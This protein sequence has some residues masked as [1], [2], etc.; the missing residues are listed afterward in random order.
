VIQIIGSLSVIGTLIALWNFFLSIAAPG[1]WW[2]ARLHDTLVLFT[3]L[4][5]AWFI[6]FTH[7]LHFS[8]N[9]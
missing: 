1:R 7:L 2:W 6:W 8:L 5:S 3:C 4:M 9:Y